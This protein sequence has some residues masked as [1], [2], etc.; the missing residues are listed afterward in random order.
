MQTTGS[1][2][3]KVQRIQNVQERKIQLNKEHQIFKLQNVC[4]NQLINPLPAFVFVPSV[5]REKQKLLAG[6]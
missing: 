6:K 1:T 4:G 3:R 2:V 5:F